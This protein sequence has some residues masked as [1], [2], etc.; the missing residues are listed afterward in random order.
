LP[1]Q[2]Y[3]IT[4]ASLED[5]P[6]IV[7][8]YNSTIAGRTVTADLEPVSLESRRVWFDEH[9]SDHRPLWV[10]KNDGRVI[11]WLSFQSFYGR[12]AYNA[13]AELS[14]YISEDYRAKGV[15]SRF[16]EKAIRD[17]P[18]L[19]LSNLVGFVFGHN[20]ASLAL[21]KKFGFQQ[22]GLLPKVAKLD[23]VERDLVILG[24]RLC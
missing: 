15:G 12:A 17:C 11:A 10:M 13:T 23:G 3:Q 20:E 7:E 24:L 16:L 6:A 4:D 2:P 21:L 9:S 18:R 8:I 14:I 19:S 5:L 1:E 22:W